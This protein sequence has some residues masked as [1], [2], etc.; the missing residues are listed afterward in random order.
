MV[1]DTLVICPQIPYPPP[2]PVSSIQSLPLSLPLPNHDTPTTSWIPCGDAGW[3]GGTA[4]D[5][6][7]GFD[8][9]GANDVYD[10][11]VGGDPSAC[12]CDHVYLA[13]VADSDEWEERRIYQNHHLS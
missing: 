8:V 9:G 2:N 3:A 11:E 1:S 6:A 13:V 5:K 12:D 4:D 10:G 7:V